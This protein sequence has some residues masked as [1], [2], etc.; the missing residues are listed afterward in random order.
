MARVRRGVAVMPGGVRWPGIY[1]A[2]L[3]RERECHY[4]YGEM[5]VWADPDDHSAGFSCRP[6]NRL[7]ALE[8]GEPVVVRSHELHGRNLSER[9]AL[10]RLDPRQWVSV[11][12]DDTITP[13]KSPVV[14]P[15]RPTL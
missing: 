4:R 8:A 2:M 14:D 5:V 12:S 15:I 1:A 13:A 10:L 3:A 7:D 11:H 9:P 6:R